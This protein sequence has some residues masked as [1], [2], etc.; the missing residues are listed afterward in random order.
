MSHPWTNHILL[1]VHQAL[2][3]NM[4]LGIFISLHRVVSS[5]VWLLFQTHVE[6][7]LPP[8]S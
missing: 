2:A 6:F 7:V 8:A 4:T 1:F 5:S 3:S